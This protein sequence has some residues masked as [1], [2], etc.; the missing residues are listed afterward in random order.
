MIYVYINNIPFWE[1]RGVDP[2]IEV[3]RMKAEMEIVGKLKIDEKLLNWYIRALGALK[4]Q[5][6]NYGYK[7]EAKRIDNKCEEVFGLALPYFKGY[8]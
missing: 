6:I 1:T 5:L 4:V 3:E 8:G 2:E 7:K